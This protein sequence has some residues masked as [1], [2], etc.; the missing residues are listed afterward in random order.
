MIENKDIVK[1][2]QKGQFSRLSFLTDKQLL[3]SHEKYYGYLYFF[4]D[5]QGKPTDDLLKEIIEYKGDSALAFAYL[6][7]I[8]SEVFSN[9]DERYIAAS[10]FNVATEKDCNNSEAWWGLFWVTDDSKAFLR[11]IKIDYLNENFSEIESKIRAISRYKDIF[12]FSYTSDEWNELK[13]ILI[14]SE[15]ANHEEVLRLFVIL[16]YYLDQLDEGVELIMKLNRV[17]A[18]IIKKYCD[19]GKIDIDTALSKIYDF[20]FDNFLEDDHDRIYDEYLKI[21]LRGES[22]LTKVGLMGKAFKAKKYPEVIALYHEEW[23]NDSLFKYDLEPRLYYLLSKFYINED[24]DQ[25][26]YGY[27]ISK[28]KND[29]LYKVFKCKDLIRQLHNYLSRSKTFNHPIAVWGLYQDAEKL[30]E[31]SDLVG[32]YLYEDIYNELLLLEEKWD[33]KYFKDQF[34]ELKTDWARTN[35]SYDDFCNFCFYGIK[36]KYYQYIIDRVY[37]YHLNQKPTITT[38]NTLGVCYERLKLHK[39]SYKYYKK[40]A[41]IMEESGEYSH[42]VIGNYL[43][44]IEKIE[45]DYPKE[46]YDTWRD[47]LNLSLVS[48]FQWNIFLAAGRNRLYKYSPFNLNTLDSLM[49]QYFYFPEKKQLNDPIEMPGIPNI[50]KDFFIDSGYRICSLSQNDNSMLMWSHYTENHQGI[51]VEYQ[52]GTGLPVG[53]GLGDVK[54]ANEVRRYKEQDK[55]VFNQ[56]LLTKNKEWSYEKEVRLMA[57]KM[58]KVHY[59]KYEYPNPNRKVINA[60]VVSITLGC[61]F[62]DSKIQ[63]IRNLVVSMNDK[64]KCHEQKIALRKAQISEENLFELEYISI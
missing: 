43:A 46:S 19:L 52:F 51:M 33:K 11:S 64:R 57:Y 16:H 50:G 37:D 48:T 23:D 36:N 49:N 41:Q 10:F 24:F 7:Q 18:V 13:D 40:A 62:P 20:E 32:H 14:G 54:Y 35:F 28:E 27:V 31:D 3:L 38:Y 30:L 53:V 26:I 44:S 1:L 58:D 21:H 59:S 12:S 2:I 61:N 34:E 47:R 29:V 8:A 56:F 42:V 63:L 39:K 45:L 5:T 60:Q 4:L 55:Y 25:D 9:F 6:G 17:D 22:K 15:L